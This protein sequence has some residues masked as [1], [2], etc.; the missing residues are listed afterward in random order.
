MKIIILFSLTSL[1]T[2]SLHAQQNKRKIMKPK[3]AKKI[4]YKDYE[5]YDFESLSL[6]GSLVSPGDIT[7]K[8]SR[9][10]EFDFDEKVRKDFD[11]KVVQEL[12]ESY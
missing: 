2:I 12:F 10:R 7:S 9:L 1:L 5:T 11:R 4:K 6:K 3:R 8:L